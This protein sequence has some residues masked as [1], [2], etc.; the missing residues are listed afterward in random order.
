MV[1]T[2]VI[3][4]SGMEKLPPD[5]HI[6]PIEVET[7]EGVVT[8]Y[9]AQRGDNR[10]VFLSRHG[11]DHQ[12]APHEIAYRANIAALSE[13]GIT[14]IIATNAVGSLRRDLQC[15]SL[16]LLS[17][18]LDFTRKRPLSYWEGMAHPH[19]VV[20]TDFSIPY[21]PQLRAAIMA[22]AEKTGIPLLREG[23]YLC[24]DGPRFE[25]PAEVRLFAQWGA[26][27]VGMTGLPEAIFAREAGICYAGLAMVTNLGAGLTDEPVDH[28]TVMQQMAGIAQTAR[29]LLLEAIQLLADDA[30][31]LCCRPPRN[32]RG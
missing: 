32:P 28:G 8:V 27:V 7:P 3:G 4:G 29:A 30:E 26:D 10:F 6:T 16:L 18:F 31:C 25:S 9:Q 21:C 11:A 22:A 23:T 15:G 20:H 24:V 13:L 19:G 2:A 14:Q 1:R 12:I 17:D 5:Y